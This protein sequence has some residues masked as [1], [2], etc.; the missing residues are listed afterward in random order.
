MTVGIMQIL[1]ADNRREFKGALLLLM[2]QY[3]VRIKHGRPRTPQTQGLVEQANGTVKRHIRTYQSENGTQK[4]A[5]ALST[6]AYYM[7]TTW[8]EALPY[9]TTPYEALY[10]QNPY[11]NTELEEIKEMLGGVEEE[12]IVQRIERRQEGYRDGRVI[13]I[14]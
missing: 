9:G 4:W 10:I 6:I 3:N 7:N 2:K 12:D 1:Q 11:Q 8:C 5:K 13:R 14:G